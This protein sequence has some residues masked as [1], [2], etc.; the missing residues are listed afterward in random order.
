MRLTNWL[1]NWLPKSNRAARRARTKAAPPKKTALSVESLEGRLMPKTTL[2][3]D[4][5]LGLTAAGLTTTVGNPSSPLGSLKDIVG[6]ATNSGPNLSTLAADGAP[7]LAATDTVKI[8]PLALPFD[9]NGDGHNDRN[10][11]LS[12]QT[13]VLKII[14]RQYQPF[15]VDIQVGKAKDIPGIV[16]A[17]G[18][19]QTSTTGKFDAYILAGSVTHGGVDVA[20]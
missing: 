20:Q 4:F 3:V 5:G 6:G 16:G 9:Y 19:N 18:K 17:L 2:Y 13:D 7:P 15:D 11:L 10:D 8:A 12:L 14:E 1:T